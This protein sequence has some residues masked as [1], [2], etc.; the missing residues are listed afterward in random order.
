MDHN[1]DTIKEVDD[2][3]NMLQHKLKDRLKQT[4]DLSDLNTKVFKSTMKIEKSTAKLK[5]TSIKTKWYWFWEWLK[6][7]SIA[8]VIATVLIL[9]LL[10]KMGLIGNGGTTYVENN[11]DMNDYAEE[12]NTNTAADTP[13][14]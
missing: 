5:E 13:Q 11:E 4:Q 8:F 9:I 2:Q 7:A 14:D 1:D 12:D 10:K 3:V 6:W